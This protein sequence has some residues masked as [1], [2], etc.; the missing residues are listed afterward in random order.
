MVTDS[1]IIARE[2]K[3]KDR[4][5]NFKKTNQKIVSNI[6]KATRK[7]NKASKTSKSKLPKSPVLYRKNL[8][9]NLQRQFGGVFG[10]NQSSSQQGTR[11][12]GRPSGEF[13]HRSPFTGKPIPATEYYKQIR[14]FRRLRE[15]RARQ[16][17]RQVDTQQVQQLARRGIPPEQAK[18][19]VDQRQLQQVM[20][21]QIPQRINPQL[22]PEVQRRIFIQQQIQQAQQ[23]IPQRRNV[24]ASQ[25]PSNLPRYGRRGQFI[26]GDAFGNPK[27]KTFGDETSF[28][29]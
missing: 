23:Q 11:P 9:A 2:V 10:G 12:V 28:W 17:A 3:N 15:Q 6:Q 27:L 24:F 29:N 26:E 13:K 14:A 4:L 20:P 25:V 21:Q 16:V 7:I 18:Q 1:K 19:I 5:K 22:P 8:P